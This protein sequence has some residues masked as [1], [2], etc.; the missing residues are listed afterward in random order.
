MTTA[1]FFSHY[2][3]NILT[4][5][6]VNVPFCRSLNLP[7]FFVKAICSLL[8]NHNKNYF[9][10]FFFFFPPGWPWKKVVS[11]Q[12]LRSEGVFFTTIPTCLA[13]RS[14]W[15]IS[16]F[17][18]NLHHC[19]SCALPHCTFSSLLSSFKSHPRFFIS[20]ICAY[21]PFLFVTSPGLQLYQKLILW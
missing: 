15:H 7:L 16:I 17:Q 11:P 2:Y 13:N 5:C 4:S 19:W 1:A 18:S 9:P 21:H 20:K 14:Q 10:P 12:E 8:A 6:T 3:S